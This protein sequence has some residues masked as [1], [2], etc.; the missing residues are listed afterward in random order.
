MAMPSGDSPQTAQ[1]YYDYL[2][3]HHQTDGRD[4]DLARRLDLARL[5][6]G[7]RGR[8]SR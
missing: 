6:V 8:R 4:G 7:L 1:Q 3:A 5:D 2:L